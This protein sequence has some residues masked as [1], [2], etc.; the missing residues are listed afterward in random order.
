MVFRTVLLKVVHSLLP[1]HALSLL[2]SETK[3]ELR[4]SF[5]NFYSNYN[6]CLSS[7]LYSIW[8]LISLFW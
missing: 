4:V 6:K 3:T 5:R 7:G 2:P 8:L 1:T